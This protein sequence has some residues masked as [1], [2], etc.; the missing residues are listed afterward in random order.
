MNGEMNGEM[1]GTMNRTM[2]GT[3][4]TPTRNGS[5]GSGRRRVSDGRTPHGDTHENR[6]DAARSGR[7]ARGRS[8][9]DITKRQEEVT[10]E[11]TMR[12][13]TQAV[14]TVYVVLQEPK[15]DP[16]GRPDQ[17]EAHSFPVNFFVFARNTR[18]AIARVECELGRAVPGPVVM[19]L[20]RYRSWT[21][22][23]SRGSGRRSPVSKSAPH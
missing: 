16:S 9:L 8:R 23:G 17:R 18:H 1:N 21:R 4:L 19:P 11:V 3:K 15:G 5:R 20:S 12:K 2:N 6:N 7:R 13:A 22:T 10:K 14:F